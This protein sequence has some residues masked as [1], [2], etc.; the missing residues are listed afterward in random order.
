MYQF[1][2]ARIT[3]ARPSTLGEQRLTSGMFAAIAVT[4]FDAQLFGGAR[5]GPDTPDV[6]AP[7]FNPD[8]VVT[9]VDHLL[10]D[11]SRAALAERHGTDHGSD[12]HGDAQYGEGRAE[13][14]TGQRMN[15]N[16]NRCQQ[17]HG[18]AVRFDE[19]HRLSVQA[20]KAT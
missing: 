13:T 9:Q 7:V 15:R 8:E 6:P 10:L 2:P 1:W 20:S 5:A 14:M 16:T 3:C 18:Y 12:A 4:V 19:R 17:A 11:E